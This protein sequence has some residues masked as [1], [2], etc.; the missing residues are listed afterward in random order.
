MGF[1]SDASRRRFLRS[2]MWLAAGAAMG[3]ALAAL[4]GCGAAPGR[5]PAPSPAAPARLADVEKSTLTIGFIPITCATPII[6]AHPLGFY[7]KHGLDVTVKKYGGW[8]EIRDAAIA[9]EIDAA[10]LLS[11]IPVAASLGVG[12]ARVAS[13][14]PAIENINGQALTL[15]MKYKDRVKGPRDMKGMKLAVPFDFSMHNLLLRHWLA[16]GGVDPDRDVQIRVMRPPDM[17][18]NLAAGN[19]DGYFAPDPFNQ[20]AVHEG[21]G[22][23]HMLSKEIWPNH[24]CCAFA[25]KQEFIEKYPRTYHALLKAIVDATNYSRKPENR[26]EIARAIAAK[27]YLNQPVE[28]VEAVLTGRFAN[29]KGQTLDEPDRIDFDPFPWKSFAVWIQTQLVRWGYIAPQQ[30]AS[31]DFKKVADEVF[32]TGDL[33]AAQKSLGMDAPAEDYKVETIMGRRFD[34]H[35]PGDWTQKNIRA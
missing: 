9:G 11:P 8:A 27:E 10:H 35:Q 20:R 16:E 31:L 18:A 25:A 15:A 6:M 7:K 3:P 26:R 17:V 23:I 24:P 12:S 14:L 28:V 33:R 5:T 2:A 22:Y 29:G 1:V 13:R 19:V 32:L 34:P 30:A 4:A 21:I